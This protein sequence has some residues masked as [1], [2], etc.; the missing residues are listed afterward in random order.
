[1]SFPPVRSPARLHDASRTADGVADI[2]GL[3]QN[4]ILASA[5]RYQADNDDLNHVV[6]LLSHCCR[7]LD[8]QNSCSPSRRALLGQAASAWVVQWLST[9]HAM[10]CN[11]LTRRLGTT[12][13]AWLQQVK[14]QDRKPRVLFR[15]GGRPRTGLQAWPFNSL[16]AGRSPDQAT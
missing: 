5:A 4:S 9:A 14:T 12:A 6:S 11:R 2:L 1:M 8:V 7:P 3:L 10:I 16:H 15:F 13:V